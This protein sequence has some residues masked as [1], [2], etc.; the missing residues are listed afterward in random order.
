MHGGL[1]VLG[2]APG[3][4]VEQHAAGV[5]RAVQ[6]GGHGTGGPALGV[7]HPVQVGPVH[8]GVRGDS[9]KRQPGR[10]PASAQ[11]GGER[12]A[13]LAVHRAHLPVLPT[14]VPHRQATP[15]RSQACHLAVTVGFV[16]S[17]LVPRSCRS[18]VRR[19]RPMTDISGPPW[20]DHQVGG[21]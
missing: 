8:V 12:L 14:R 7:L 3:P 5:Q 6:G 9:A 13:R 15:E 10:G 17:H 11:F 19:A 2:L 4:G 16:I 18:F 21:S 1:P 20:C